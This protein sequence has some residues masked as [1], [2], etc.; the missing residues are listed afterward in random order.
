MLEK[1]EY[2]DSKNE[3][4]GNSISEDKTHSSNDVNAESTDRYD[5]DDSQ[6]PVD[7]QSQLPGTGQSSSVVNHD[8][9]SSRNV[10]NHES[11][12]TQSIGDTSRPIILPQVELNS[13]I[14]YKLA[15]D[16]EWIR[17]IVM[18]RAGKLGGKY[19][20]HCNVLNDGEEVPSELNFETQVQDQKPIE[21]ENSTQETNFCGV[22]LAH[23]NNEVEDAKDNKLKNQVKEGVYQ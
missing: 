9:S 3:K 18:N 4:Q 13:K 11:S 17:A 20:H 10:S 2:G 8:L 5:S 6:P 15:D 19:K 22:C 7:L 14:M 23:V 12:A 21:E 1:S 16:D